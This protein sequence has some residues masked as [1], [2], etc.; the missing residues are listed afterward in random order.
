MIKTTKKKSLFRKRL[1]SEWRDL[2]AS[3]CRKK[4]I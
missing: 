3:I 4:R 1:R 2:P